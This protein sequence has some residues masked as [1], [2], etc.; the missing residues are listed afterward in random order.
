MCVGHVGHGCCVCR[1]A[2]PGS[3]T[4]T[5]L[6]VAERCLDG[7]CWRWFQTGHPQTSVMYP[8]Q[9]RREELKRSSLWKIWSFNMLNQ[10]STDVIWKHRIWECIC[11]YFI[12]QTN[13]NS[14]R[15]ITI[16]VY[17]FFLCCFVSSAMHVTFSLSS[18][19]YVWLISHRPC[20]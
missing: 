5:W 17:V 6:P 11:H 1:P 12:F 18:D 7:L 8:A 9:K 14:G 19:V 3:Q 16:N 4:Y 20:P 13:T 10:C 2:H 15:K